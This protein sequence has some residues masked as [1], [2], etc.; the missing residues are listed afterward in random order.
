MELEE[1]KHKAQASPYMGT[2]EEILLPPL[3]HGAGLGALRTLLLR[4]NQLEEHAFSALDGLFELRELDLSDNLITL[5]PSCASRLLSLTSVDVSRNTL[6]GSHA[7][8]RKLPRLRHAAPGG[9][10]VDRDGYPLMHPEFCTSTSS[11][12]EGSQSSL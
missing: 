1:D 2:L 7:V 11:V 8:L 6:A 9:Q 12:N 5:L 4:D 10:Q 3:G